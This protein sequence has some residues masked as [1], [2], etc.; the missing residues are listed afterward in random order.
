MIFSSFR[1]LCIILCVYQH[2]A[3]N[4]HDNVWLTVTYS[5]IYMA[6][7]SPWNIFWYIR[8]HKLRKSL[9]IYYAIYILVKF[10]RKMRFNYRNPYMG[11]KFYCNEESYTPHPPPQPG[12]KGLCYCIQIQPSFIIKVCE[13][14]CMK[15]FISHIIAKCCTLFKKNVGLHVYC[16]RLNKVILT[17]TPWIH[18][19]IKQ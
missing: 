2:I 18:R 13:C 17:L 12:I 16:I 9:F 11:M 3:H 19:Y 1:L 4:I 14:D 10:Y 6:L 5:P 7:L 8:R 15:V